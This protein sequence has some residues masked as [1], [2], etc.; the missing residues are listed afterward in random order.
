[1]AFKYR[2]YIFISVR[3][4]E[5]LP[6]SWFALHGDER[7][8][9]LIIALNSEALPVLLL[10]ERGGGE[11]SALRKLI[12][13]GLLDPSARNTIIICSLVRASISFYLKSDT[14]ELSALLRMEAGSSS[15]HVL[16]QKIYCREIWIT[17][18]CLLHNIKHRLITSEVIMKFGTLSWHSFYLIDYSFSSLKACPA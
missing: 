5:L 1:M 11:C 8:F 15:F 3:L 14:F 13:S 10:I 2:K 4:C 6:C 9:M 18:K 12:L 7:K 16:I 17:P